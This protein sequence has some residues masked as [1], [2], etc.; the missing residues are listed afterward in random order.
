M[1]FEGKIKHT[2]DHMD[3]G[4]IV[5]V[6]VANECVTESVADI[7]FYTRIHNDSFNVSVDGNQVTIYKHLNNERITITETFQLT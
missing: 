7:V 2:I 5:I 4:S 6:N 1:D 3:N